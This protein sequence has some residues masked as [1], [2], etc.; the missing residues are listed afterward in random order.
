MVLYFNSLTH[1]E[2]A[3]V[4]MGRDAEENAN[5]MDAAYSYDVWFS[6]LP[7]P[8]ISKINSKLNY[9][10]QAK[11]NNSFSA[12]VYLRFDRLNKLE[13]IPEELIEEA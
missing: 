13:E 1:P 6:I 8:I 9:D 11:D 4:F 5:L 3:V 10:Q 7:Q 12:Q 2:R